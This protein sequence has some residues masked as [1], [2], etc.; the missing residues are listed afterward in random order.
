MIKKN[1]F[2]EWLKLALEIHEN[3][4][5]YSQ[6]KFINSKTP[7]TVICKIHG[8]WS[9]T[10]SSHTDKNRKRGCPACGGSQKKTSKQFIQ[11]ASIKNDKVT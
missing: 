11:E 6:V 7:V 1:K 10:P 9:C 8:H 3:K 2:E 4:Y 5:D